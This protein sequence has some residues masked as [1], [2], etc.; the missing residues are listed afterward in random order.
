MWHKNTPY[1]PINLEQLAQVI[2]R[3]RF[4]NGV[5]TRV[6]DTELSSDLTTISQIFSAPDKPPEQQG[7]TPWDMIQ[8]EHPLLT[9]RYKIFKK[10]LHADDP[11]AVLRDFSRD[12][13]PSELYHLQVLIKSRALSKLPSV[14]KELPNLKT[15]EWGGL[16]KVQQLSIRLHIRRLE[17]ITVATKSGLPPR[18]FRLTRHGR[19]LCSCCC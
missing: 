12:R 19:Y 15:V 8:E 18:G 2:D 3:A 17:N 4:D 9:R 6:L 7:I 11:L 5:L 13:R 16:S 14:E 10:A 1:D